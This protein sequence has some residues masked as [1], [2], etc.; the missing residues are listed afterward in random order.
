MARGATKKVKGWRTRWRGR[1]RK[2]MLRQMGKITQKSKVIRGPM[3]TTSSGTNIFL[4]KCVGNETDTKDP[5]G[6]N[7]V[8]LLVPR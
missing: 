5:A 6:R 8:P 2:S 4:S 7:E 3:L 1:M